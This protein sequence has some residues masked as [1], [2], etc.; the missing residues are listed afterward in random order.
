MG[1]NASAATCSAL[2]VHA[3][4]C[5]KAYLTEH[6]LFFSYAQFWLVLQDIKNHLAEKRA[7]TELLWEET[8]P[9]YLHQQYC[10]PKSLR[11]SI[12]SI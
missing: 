11:E 3:R 7:A 10:Y 8:M 1:F 2:Y 5:H 4:S 9:E 6:R 12:V